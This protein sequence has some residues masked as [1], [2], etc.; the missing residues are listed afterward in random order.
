MRRTGRGHFRRSGDGNRSR[1]AAPAGA[2]QLPLRTGTAST[3]PIRL[4]PVPIDRVRLLSRDGLVDFWGTLHNLGRTVP[5]GSPL[6]R[7]DP[8]KEA[9]LAFHQPPQHFPEG[10]AATQDPPQSALTGGFAP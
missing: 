3:P 5:L 9:F 6:V 1:R 4:V 7:I 8:A 2:I 10:R